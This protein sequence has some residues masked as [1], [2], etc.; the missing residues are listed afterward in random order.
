MGNRNFALK[1]SLMETILVCRPSGKNSFFPVIYFICSIIGMGWMV[2][3]AWNGTP[4]WGEFCLFLALIIFTFFL[5]RSQFFGEEHLGIDGKDFVIHYVKYFPFKRDK[6]IPLSEIAEVRFN[7]KSKAQEIGE[8]L[9]E[10]RGGMVNEDG[11]FLMTKSGKIYIFGK[12]L[13]E[14]RSND[15]CELLQ[16][17]INVEMEIVKERES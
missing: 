4:R 15:F 3:S 11:I 2:Y 13:S 9:M 16:E 8:I 12:D 14:K 6:R 17:R 10:L 7:Q 1:V 5:A